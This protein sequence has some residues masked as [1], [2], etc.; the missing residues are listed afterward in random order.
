M[1]KSKEFEFDDFERMFRIADVAKDTEWSAFLTSPSTLGMF[2]K[3]M[4][5]L[6]HGHSA[7]PMEQLQ[8]AGIAKFDSFDSSFT[9]DEVGLIKRLCEKFHLNAVYVFRILNSLIAKS[10]ERNFFVF[11][12]TISQ[13]SIESFVMRQTLDHKLAYLRGLTFFTTRLN[14]RA[15]QTP[16]A[17]K[18]QLEAFRDNRLFQVLVQNLKDT[19]SIPK[20]INLE[21]ENM[22]AL[23]L[24]KQKELIL[25]VLHNL[26]VLRDAHKDKGAIV[27]G[28]LGC[29][30]ERD[31]NS[32]VQSVFDQL[33]FD[34][35]K[36][37]AKKE[38]IVA[39]ISVAVKYLF[40]AFLSAPFKTGLSVEARHKEA[41][42]TLDIMKSMRDRVMALDD[43]LHDNSQVAELFKLFAIG[44]AHV[45]KATALKSED[46]KWLNDTIERV[47]DRFRDS[48]PSMLTEVVCSLKEKF[49][50]DSCVHFRWSLKALLNCSCLVFSKDFLEDSPYFDDPATFN[51]LLIKTIKEAFKSRQIQADFWE[52]FRVNDNLELVVRK[53]F[54]AYPHSTVPFL[55]LASALLG[56]NSLTCANNLKAILTDLQYISFRLDSELS[57]LFVQ[58]PSDSDEIVYEATE[59]VQLKGHIV[60][61]KGTRGQQNRQDTLFRV[62]YHFN[63][64]E[65]VY[66]ELMQFC[67]CDDSS[68]PP[69]S[70]GLSLIFFC[71]LVVASPGT[72]FELHEHL[73]AKKA[74]QKRQ[75]MTGIECT[76]P[77]TLIGLLVDLTRK[78]SVEEDNPVV[79]TWL[80]KAVSALLRSSCFEPTA[81]M[82]KMNRALKDNHPSFEKTFHVFFECAFSRI[83]VLEESK[84][85]GLYYEGLTA[86]LS[87]VE[88]MVSHERTLVEVLLV[89]DHSG[90]AEDFANMQAAL[91]KEAMFMQQ[92]VDSKDIEAFEEECCD[93]FN[94]KMM[95]PTLVLPY[96]FDGFWKGLLLKVS[97]WLTNDDFF[98]TNKDLCLRYQLYTRMFGLLTALVSKAAV[99]SPRHSVEV[100]KQ[101]DY[102]GLWAVKVS[103]L[104]DQLPIQRFFEKVFALVD[105][106]ETVPGAIRGRTGCGLTNKHV[107]NF[108]ISPQLGLTAEAV[109]QFLISACGFFSEGLWLCSQLMGTQEEERCAEWVN[110][111]KNCFFL[112]D[113]YLRDTV[114]VKGSAYSVNFVAQVMALAQNSADDSAMTRMQS[115]IDEASFHC[116]VFQVQQVEAFEDP[117][118]NILC[119]HY[120]VQQMQSM[121]VVQPR[122]TQRNFTVGSAVLDFLTQLMLFWRR[123]SKNKSP[124]LLDFIE[125][126]NFEVPNREGLVQGLVREV[127]NALRE[128]SLKALDFLIECNRSQPDFVLQVLRLYEQDD[129][130]ANAFFVVLKQLVRGLNVVVE[131]KEAR[132]SLSGPFVKVAV[133]KLA[134]LVFG[135]IRNQHL[136]KAHVDVLWNS[137][138]TDVSELLFRVLPEFV[139][140][141]REVV[142]FAE[143]FVDNQEMLIAPNLATRAVCFLKLTQRVRDLESL[144]HCLLHM[145]QI[146]TDC[147]FNAMLGNQNRFMK[148]YAKDFLV[149]MFGSFQSILANVV[150]KDLLALH[151]LFSQVQS[152]LQS[153][154]EDLN[155]S[156]ANSLWNQNYNVMTSLNAQITL[157]DLKET[158][159]GGTGDEAKVKAL[160]RRQSFNPY[161]IYQ[162]LVLGKVAESRALVVADFGSVLN[163]LG[164]ILKSKEGLQRGFADFV[165]LVFSV[166]LGGHFLGSKYSGLAMPKTQGGLATTANDSLS[167]HPN[168]SLNL[169][170]P[171]LTAHC[172]HSSLTPS[173]LNPSPPLQKT[174][175]GSRLEDILHNPFSDSATSL[176]FNVMCFLMEANQRAPQGKSLT[177][178]LLQV[179]SRIAELGSLMQLCIEEGIDRPNRPQ[180]PSVNFVFLNSL[181][182]LTI[183]HLVLLNHCLCCYLDKTDSTLEQ[184]RQ[185]LSKTYAVV[186]QVSIF[187]RQKDRLKPLKDTHE[188]I[189]DLCAHFFYY[190]RLIGAKNTLRDLEQLWKHFTLK[191]SADLRRFLPVVANIARVNPEMVQENDIN[192][193]SRLLSSRDSS[194][195]DI[196]TVLGILFDNYFERKT[197]IDMFVE[198]ELL[199]HVLQMSILDGSAEFGRGELYN[200]DRSTEC[201]SIFCHLMAFLTNLCL[202]GRDMHVLQQKLMA[203]FSK[204]FSKIESVLSLKGDKQT[205]DLSASTVGR[206]VHSYCF[207]QELKAVVSFL[208]ALA[209]NKSNLNPQFESA[210]SLLFVVL[211]E[212]TLAFLFLDSPN[213]LSRLARAQQTHRP[214]ELFRPQSIFEA[215]LERIVVRSQTIPQ[216]PRTVSTDKLPDYDPKRTLSYNLLAKDGGSLLAS[217]AL[218]GLSLHSFL[219]EVRLM[220]VLFVTMDLFR[221]LA[222]HISA[223]S[224]KQGTVMREKTAE[225][226][227]G[228]SLHFL[229]V[230]GYLRNYFLKLSHAEFFREANWHAHLMKHSEYSLRET[231]GLFQLEPL[232]SYQE[233][234]NFVR[235]G[236]ELAVFN[237]RVVFKWAETAWLRLTAEEVM[238]LQ[239]H[240]EESIKAVLD[241]SKAQTVVSTTKPNMT[242][243]KS[244]KD[245]VGDGPLRSKNPKDLALSQNL[246]VKN[247]SSDQ[248]VKE[249]DYLEAK[250]HELHKKALD[251][252]KIAHK[253]KN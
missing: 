28:V 24:L 214:A 165:S 221:V 225:F 144:D 12:K 111:F 172:F 121:G 206:H 216:G 125:S 10:K 228:L 212:R 122:V 52:E 167:N 210:F 108:E 136:K 86:I 176:E 253:W 37:N 169:T 42:V 173:D 166:G 137:L 213:G 203:V 190:C 185:T 153:M 243:N 164:A 7:N 234:K 155:A 99:T 19:S 174:Q 242:T 123:V 34:M 72:V 201:H 112:R 162:N 2:T 26:F 197:R 245:H 114:R 239:R 194:A 178:S 32:G 20:S 158:M 105:N 119:L 100:Y 222:V 209:A 93:F 127:E 246:S 182:R 75:A 183:D 220:E 202:A 147:F 251:K 150:S 56:N 134:E 21:F 3:P 82:L 40:V 128:K 77:V 73:F 22:L 14:S 238:T 189:E 13:E 71:K 95:E 196:L 229:E 54:E 187:L 68:C 175:P 44:T 102:K 184:F 58:L 117:Q 126:W 53:A 223:S 17:E 208:R 59:D 55:K 92:P 233:T 70:V 192:A 215:D 60:I 25:R 115:L 152:L 49:V 199:D 35:L 6:F 151:C 191:P 237:Q 211:C 74:E 179:L 204:L 230:Q 62:R 63:F 46:G 161:L 36:V 171:Q 104:I 241:F 96:H 98:C 116:E 218:S 65:C 109:Q 110:K 195:R 89:H 170:H 84:L 186:H 129:P 39:R 247:I 163:H 11:L 80:F 235:R 16:D 23:N 90:V 43:G 101:N 48:H 149:R 41:Q 27:L 66:R 226:Y 47:S 107:F 146:V 154:V 156:N 69:E 45:L 103:E 15:M 78:L 83:P 51:R 168:H 188:L 252:F 9:A 224:G 29:L 231:Q 33:S 244:R 141:V 87:I 130:K 135:L 18:L 38:Q 159:L 76:Y 143:A 177:T 4:S 79:H 64:L 207:L 249:T 8:A 1:T 236:F 94:H 200:S 113:S 5:E 145:M 198:S 61:A 217:Q 180:S 91:V 106:S 227:L 131:S 248:T 157:V 31:L 81:F 30:G 132:T 133:V 219:V 85:R 193:L 120:T 232:Y 57:P 138:F 160:E 97:H 148:D 67:F 142:A 240:Q 205:N 139:Q 88:S 50:D 140:S 181:L 118:D 124:S 250:Y